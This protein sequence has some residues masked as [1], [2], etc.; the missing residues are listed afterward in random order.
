MYDFE[1]F[2]SY[3]YRN[4]LATLSNANKSMLKKMKKMSTTTSIYLYRPTRR[5]ISAARER[6]NKPLGGRSTIVNQSSRRCDCSGL[7][8]CSFPVVVA[9][10]LRLLLLRRSTS[11]TMV[12]RYHVSTIILLLMTTFSTFALDVAEV[13]SYNG[14]EGTACAPQF[15]LTERLSYKTWQQQ[16]CLSYEEEM[17]TQPT[18]IIPDPSA[19]SNPA[20]GT[21]RPLYENANAFYS[22]YR[23]L[24]CNHGKVRLQRFP[25]TQQCK[26]HDESAFE[27]FEFKEDDC[28]QPNFYRTGK[29]TGHYA[30]QPNSHRFICHQSEGMP[31]FVTV[32]LICS[33]ILF[34]CLIT[35]WYIV[36]SEPIPVDSVKSKALDEEHISP[37]AIKKVN[38]SR[39]VHLQPSP[40]AILTRLRGMVSPMK[41]TNSYAKKRKILGMETLR[42]YNDRIN[43]MVKG[44]IRGWTDFWRRP[45]LDA[46][47]QR[48]NKIQP[49]ISIL[50]S[51]PNSIGMNYAAEH[52]IEDQRPIHISLPMSTSSA[53]MLPGM[54]QFGKSD[55][56]TGGRVTKP[57]KNKSIAAAL[58]QQRIE[59][60][61]SPVKET[62]TRNKQTFQNSGSA[63]TS[64]PSILKNNNLP[65]LA[66]SASAAVPAGPQARYKPST[67]E[68]LLPPEDDD[69]EGVA[70]GDNLYYTDQLHQPFSLPAGSPPGG[71]TTSSS[72]SSS[73]TGGAGLHQT[74]RSTGLVV[75]LGG[76]TSGGTNTSSSSTSIAPV[77]PPPI[78]GSHFR[79]RT[80]PDSSASETEMLQ[81]GT[82]SDVLQHQNRLL[83]QGDHADNPLALSMSRSS[84]RYVGGKRIVSTDESQMTD[85]EKYL[86]S[87]FKETEVKKIEILQPDELDKRKD[88]VRKDVGMY[89]YNE[90]ATKRGSIARE[91]LAKG[92]HTSQK[93]GKFFLHHDVGKAKIRHE[94][95]SELVTADE[96]E[97]VESTK[98]KG[99]F[100]WKNR[101]TGAYTWRNPYAKKHDISKQKEKLLRMIDEDGEEREQRDMFLEEDNGTNGELS[102]SSSL[103]ED[104]DESASLSKTAS[105]PPGASEMNATGEEAAVEVPIDE[106]WRKRLE[107]NEPLQKD[108]EKIMNKQKEREQLRSR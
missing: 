74:I 27:I 55:A 51:S 66:G 90:K 14:P 70:G 86:A 64:R 105:S 63:G 35:C 46:E 81:L 28:F 3:S 98:K 1:S 78:E 104:E 29:T 16:I 73:R 87:F 12:L 30:Y 57:E 65:A 11:A 59:S 22:G 20:L 24:E 7:R 102:F 94:V 52:A 60:G 53:T 39:K 37:R 62:D 106:K 67:E 69:D 18:P 107:K 5:R 34:C 44:N 100:Y 76:G 23:L 71:A 80:T 6:R 42:E 33:G 15:E 82:T 2:T 38:K 45:R 48:N 9:A 103:G 17:S 8:L 79:T 58:D 75:P 95:V 10:V 43:K 54:E 85:E 91:A 83:Q 47:D 32:V 36:G 25:A 13:K 108:I 92:E 49:E 89:Q 101:V 93:N 97:K 50:D 40:H 56:T 41:A 21:T 26:L 4:K 31:V 77:P 99:R 68:R 84:V 61:I 96:W 72:S 88:L 19:A